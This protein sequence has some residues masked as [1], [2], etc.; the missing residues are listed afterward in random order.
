MLYR[1]EVPDIYKHTAIQNHLTVT[2]RY[3]RSALHP[4]MH[5]S[6]GIRDAP[7]LAASHARGVIVTSHARGVIVIDSDEDN[8]VGLNMPQSSK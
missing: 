7:S 1:Q 6:G 3:E 8:D 5:K 4:I 2:Y